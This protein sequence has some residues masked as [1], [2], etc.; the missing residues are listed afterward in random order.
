MTSNGLTLA[1]T[2]LPA[3]LAVCRLAPDSPI[4][5]WASGGVLSIAARTP[6]ELSLV[7]ADDAVPDGTVAERG[8]RALQV[9][10]PLP[11]EMVGVMAALAVPL[12]E[13]QVSIF[14]VSTFL[15]DYLLVRAGDLDWAVQALRG[16][17]HR[18][19]IMSNEQ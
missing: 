11:F 9:A 15:T 17:G 7:C 14:V 16:A 10:G 8:W 3:T 18:S 1:L 6:D 5:D 19:L 2:V 4:P 13:A 12:S